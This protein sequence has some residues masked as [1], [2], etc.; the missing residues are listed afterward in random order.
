MSPRLPA[1]ERRQQLLDAA[2]RTFAVD[3]YRGT[4]MNRVAEAAGVTKP[5]LYQHFASK[6]DLFV[7][8]LASVGGELE[9]SILDATSRATS[10]R[11][12]VEGGFRAYFSFVAE[13]RDAFL[14]LFG[15]GTRLDPEFSQIVQGFE[16]GMADTIAALIVVDGL[17]DSQR[18]LLGHG[19]VGI[20]EVTC[21]HWLRTTDAGLDPTPEALAEQVAGLAWSGLRG[22]E[23]A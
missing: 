14:V 20:A 18:R 17:D 8:L 21:R 22:I 7:E 5:V 23:A 4:S 13:H 3:G 16:A 12:Q 9:K 11:G 15:A 10:P 2:L 1:A 6:R 19:I